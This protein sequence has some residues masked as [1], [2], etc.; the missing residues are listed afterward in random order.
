MTNQ[1]NKQAT[2]PAEVK[3]KAVKPVKAVA[4]IDGDILPDT[5][6]TPKSQEQRDE[7]FALEAVVELTADEAKLFGLT[8]SETTA[9]Q[10]PA[11]PAPAAGADDEIK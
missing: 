2:K 3:P 8:A 1:V 7:L 4:R 11:S 5:I 6:F 9:P 10:T